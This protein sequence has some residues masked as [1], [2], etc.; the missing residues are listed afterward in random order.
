MGAQSNSQ[1]NLDAAICGRLN[2]GRWRREGPIE[3]TSVGNGVAGRH[4]ASIG[5]V[6]FRMRPH[7]GHATWSP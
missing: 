6:R 1:D 5:R 4:P 3:P 2:E 7:V